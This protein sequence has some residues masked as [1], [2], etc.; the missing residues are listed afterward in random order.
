ML[1]ILL[2]APAQLA[3]HGEWVPL[4][5]LP[6]AGDKKPWSRVL[7]DAVRARLTD[8]CDSLAE[9]VKPPQ[10]LDAAKS[11]AIRLRKGLRPT[12]L[13]GGK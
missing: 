7:Q 6:D 12:S 2:L 3:N 8:Y 1:G 9:Q 10:R 11:L 4:H 13:T 5:F